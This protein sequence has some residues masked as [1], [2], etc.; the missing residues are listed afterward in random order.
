MSN[1]VEEV[2]R[3]AQQWEKNWWMTA[4]NQHPVEIEKNK[5]VAKL[6]N[7]DEGLP[8]RTVIDIGCGPLSMLLRVPVKEG[9]ALDPLFFD[10][11]EAAY[12]QKGIKRLVK[13]AEELN[14]KDGKFDE[15]WIYNCL[16]HVKDPTKILQNAIAVADRVRIF[17][18]TH[19]PP[20]EGHLHMLTPELLSKPFQDAGWKA[21]HVATGFFDHDQLEGNYFVAIFTKLNTDKL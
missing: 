7:I 1:D 9:Y 14:I 5:Y 18:W 6:L 3:K 16:Q 20:Y 17:E 12:F 10:D 4:R 13:P 11:L 8:D 2:W 21:Q 15:A 19:I